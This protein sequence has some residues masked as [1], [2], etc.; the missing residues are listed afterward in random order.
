MKLDPRIKKGKKPL[1]CFD[2]DEAKQFIGQEGYFSNNTTDFQD[3]NDA[4]RD[5][6]QDVIDSYDNTPPF[7]CSDYIHK[8][9]VLPLVYCFVSSVTSYKYFLP[10]EWVKEP[11]PKWRAFKDHAEYKEFLN[12]GIIESWVKIKDKS[13]DKIYELMYV[14]GGDDKICLGGMMFSASTLFNTFELFN[15]STGQWQPF[16]VEE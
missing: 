3:L 4:C 16:G 5:V 13:A 11:E 1:T 2:S 9:Y 7:K 14:G 6:L 15:E 10:S 8:N 12:D